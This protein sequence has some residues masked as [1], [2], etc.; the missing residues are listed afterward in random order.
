[1][2][3]RVARPSV[4]LMIGI[5]AFLVVAGLAIWLLEHR[6]GDRYS[7]W[8]LLVGLPGLYLAGLV[9][10]GAPKWLYIPGLGLMAV[11]YGMQ[12]VIWRRQKASRNAAPRDS[13]G[14]A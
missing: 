12:I 4:S 5:A 8:I 6:K 9:P 10:F 3:T 13:S 1:M 14:S 7:G 2:I 11:S